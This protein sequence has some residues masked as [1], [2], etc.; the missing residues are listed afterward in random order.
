MTKISLNSS[1]FVGKQCGYGPSSEWDTCVDAVNAYYGPPE[2]FASRFEHMLVEVKRLGYDAVDIWTAGQLSW[3]W[4]TRE[5]IATARAL[6]DKH[7]LAVTSL[8]D[9]FGKTRD[10][11]VAAC[12]LA[13]GVNTN[14]LSGGCPVLRKER[15]FVIEMLEKYNLRLGLENHPERSAQEILDQIGDGGNGRIGTTIDT[16]W[17]ATQAPDVI[18]A[19]KGLKG[20]IYHV[21]LKDVLAGAADQNVGFGRGVAPLVESV[22]TLKQLGYKGDYSVEI[23]SIDHDPTTELAE[24]LML[25]RRWLSQ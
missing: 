13:V 18:E 4:A 17:Y 25:V 16:G 19:I 24:G 12:E 20:H 22:Q 6:L 21:H 1:S 8:G 9:N 23:H 11:F 5:Q 14:L 15:A 2:T 10:D 3:R 7:K